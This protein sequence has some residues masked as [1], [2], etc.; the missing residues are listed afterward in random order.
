[1]IN[2][3]QQV[4]PV[5]K[6]LGI[7]IPTLIAKLDYNA[8]NVTPIQKIHPVLPIS[9]VQEEVVLLIIAMIH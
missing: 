5:R 6:D 8:L 9:R 1:M 2:L 4:I 7:V 3:A